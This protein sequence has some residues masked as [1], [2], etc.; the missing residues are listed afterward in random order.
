MN[1]W[2]T[3]VVLFCM[4]IATGTMTG[5]DSGGGSNTQ[6]LRIY[7][8]WADDGSFTADAGD[9]TARKFQLTLNGGFT[10]DDEV[11]YFDN[12]GAKDAGFDTFGNLVNTV[13]PKVYGTAPNA[14]LKATTS[15]G[16]IYLSCIVDT[17]VLDTKTGKLSFAITYLA[18]DRPKAD[19]AFTDPV[20]IITNNAAT[21]QREVW[22][23]QIN[24]DSATF[25]PVKNPDGSAVEGTYT[26]RFHKALGDA[27]GV[28]CA[29][30]R[31]TQSISVQQYLQGWQTRFGT[32][33]PNAT[34]MFPANNDQLG[35]VHAVTLSNPVYDEATGSF[36]FTA[37]VIYSPFL[38]IG[39]T[40]L[41]VKL[42][43]LFV[44]AGPGGFPKYDGNVFSIQYRNSTTDTIT[45]WLEPTQP[46]CSKQVAHDQGCSATDWTALQNQFTKS[47]TKFVIIDANGTSK[48]TSVLSHTD[49]APG[50]TLR[51]IPPLGS[52]GMPQ[53][54]F[55]AAGSETTAGPA[56]WVTKKGISMPAVGA[57]T[58]VEFNPD[59]NHIL[60]FDLSA[61]EGVNIQVT[62][63]YEGPGTADVTTKECKIPLDDYSDTNSDG[64]PY[65]GP[66][67]M[68]GSTASS[69]LHP[70]WYPYDSIEAAVLKPSWVVAPKDFTLTDSDNTKYAAILADATQALKG[71][72]AYFSGQDSRWKP[73]VHYATDAFTGYMLADGAIGDADGKG[74]FLPAKKA[75]HIWWA[76]NPVALGW[77]Q[78][79]QQNGK[80]NCD[81]YAWAYDE[82]VWKPADFTKSNNG[83]TTDGNVNPLNENSIVPLVSHALSK[84][85]YLN[86]DIA[87]VK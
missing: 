26:L 72:I 64:C 42:P 81:S 30:Q 23:H 10:A 44:D 57:V 70:R 27:N 87:Q 48:N 28:T 77:K 45:V 46:P 41:T 39:K 20:L 63:S 84:N 15:K 21:I 24:G 56:T 52:D 79:V 7:Q 12:R 62:M 58:K 65:G 6:S 19:L 47:G 74:T 3:F 16:V 25:E 78:Y 71:W 80:G 13:W 76:T 68:T 8:I 29:P 51:I 82:K 73:P 67:T 40:G 36:S 11:M 55:G 75:Y 43:T 38:P 1:S 59:P 5:C 34:L 54:Y 53:W 14:T 69:C 2:I 32:N 86:I 61:I 18:G 37:K 85:T 17:P 49:L 50:E 22:S 9:A 33:P 66:E 35:G 4:V 83:F 60:W 31:K